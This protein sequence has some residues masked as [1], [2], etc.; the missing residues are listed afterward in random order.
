MNRNLVPEA[1]PVDDSVTVLFAVIAAFNRWV[2]ELVVGVTVKVP[3][4]S[5]AMVFMPGLFG[6]LR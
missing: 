6:S 5:V 3:P 1:A 2:E 4:A